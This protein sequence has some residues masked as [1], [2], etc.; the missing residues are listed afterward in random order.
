MR[1]RAPV[2]NDLNAVFAL[3]A[4]RDTADIGAPDYTLEDLT[5]EWGLS[6]VDLSRDVVVAELDARGPAGEIVGYAIVRSVG[7]LAIV[8]PDHEGQGIGAQLLAWVEGRARERG[9]ERHRQW[10][11]ASNE[12][13]CALLLGAGYEPVRSYWRFVRPLDGGEAIS[14]SP[15]PAGVRLRA[16]D[17]AADAATLHALHDTTFGGNPDYRSESP[18]AFREEHL[19]AHDLDPELSRIAERDGELVGYLL[20]RRWASEG[21]TFIDLLGVHP[22]HRGAGLATALLQSTFSLGAQRGLREVQLGVA[23]DNPRALRL[24]ERCGMSPRFRFDTFERPVDA[25]AS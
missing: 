24:Y 22:A 18:E 5:E 13:G 25:A 19:R 17:P 4:A 2:Q 11:A 6:E 9:E 21:V 15:P 10:V 20:A 12:R 3:M 1:L 16:L 14:V 8:A 23:S 7:T